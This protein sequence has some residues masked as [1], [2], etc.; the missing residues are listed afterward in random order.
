MPP[1]TSLPPRP[2]DRLFFALYPDAAARERLAA[3][4][5]ELARRHALRGRPFAPERLHVTLAMAGDHVGLP[6]DLLGRVLAAGDAMRC[7]PFDVGFDRITTFVRPRKRPCVLLAGQGVETMSALHEALEAALRAGGVIDAPQRRFRPHLTLQY[8]DRGWPDAPIEPIRWTARKLV[9][10]R[11]LLGRSRHV[12][13][14]R[15]P[16]GSG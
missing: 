6:D 9:L 10:M 16:F 4:G 8:D 5:Q 13:L 7:S 1:S 14:A 11:S 15:W 2:T 12:E 3:L